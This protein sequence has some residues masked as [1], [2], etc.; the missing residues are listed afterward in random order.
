[1]TQL[2]PA[3]AR[4]R[5]F[6]PIF[7][8]WLSGSLHAQTLL[9][10]LTP[11]SSPHTF[12]QPR[13]SAIV[14][15]HL[16]YVDNDWQHGR[17][18]WRTDG[19][20]EGTHMV[21]DLTLGSSSRF[22]TNLAAGPGGLWF[23]LGSE[24]W[25]SDG[26]ALGAKKITDITLGTP[27]AIIAS[28]THLFL[29]TYQS[30]SA[31]HM[32]VSDGT[33]NGTSVVKSFTPSAYAKITDVAALG[34]RI[35]F[36]LT[37]ARSTDIWTSDGTSAGTIKLTG[38]TTQPLLV[39]KGTCYFSQYEPARGTE[40]WRTDG[41]PAGTKL[42][43]DINTEV[44]SGTAQSS[45]PSDFYSNG[46]QVY[47]TARR[48]KATGY[49]LFVTDGTSQ[50][51]GLVADI[52]PGVNSGDPEILGHI[53]QDLF[54]SAR[55]P[56]H[57]RELIKVDAKGVA[58]LHHEHAAGNADGNP[59][60]FGRTTNKLLFTGTDAILFSTDGNATTP[61][62][63]YA[64]S[65]GDLQQ[66]FDDRVFFAGSLVGQD[67]SVWVTDGS[68]QGT[69]RFNTRR[70]EDST[71]F[72]QIVTAGK[73]VL[74]RT[75]TKELWHSNGEPGHAQLLSTNSTALISAGD[76][77]YYVLPWGHNRDHQI[78]YYSPLDSQPT[79][80]SSLR[81]FPYPTSNVTP[82]SYLGREDGVMFFA[83]SCSTYGE[84]LFITDG[85]SAG[86]HIV[87]DIVQYPGSSSPQ[88]LA[89]FRDGRLLFSAY[90]AATGRELYT[91]DGT[92]TGTRMI[93][94]LALNTG[95]VD[96][97]ETL[98]TDQGIYLVMDDSFVGYK[99]WFTDG[100]AAGTKMVAMINSAPSPWPESLTSY[101]G[102]VYFAFDDGIHGRELWVS[103]GTQ[104]GTTRVSDIGPGS[105][106]G[107]AGNLVST[108]DNLYFVGDDGQHGQE[109]WMSDGTAA[110]SVMVKDIAPGTPSSGLSELFGLGNRVQFSADDGLHGQELW[111]SDGT[112]NG[113]RIISNLEPGVS[114]S[115]PAQFTLAHDLSSESRVLFVA[116]HYSVGRELWMVPVGKLGASIVRDYGSACA[117]ATP[118][119]IRATGVARLG[120][121]L[122]VTLEKVN[123]GSVTALLHGLRRDHISLGNCSILV[124]GPTWTVTKLANG[125]GTS[126]FSLAV[127]N[128]PSLLGGR[129][130]SQGFE[131]G[132]GGMAL[133][134]ANLSKGLAMTIGL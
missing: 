66:N 59:R 14:G 115:S 35:L 62:A 106:S 13:E 60:V 7:C 9:E 126:T 90:E 57:G 47:F 78:W 108:P 55:L 6:L 5:L 133:G 103:N 30:P 61:L 86:T 52:W 125:T 91:S 123:A 45:H 53:G 104:A 97:V 56:S 46:Q 112:A 72:E 131:L 77:A 24:L 32:Y 4:L 37:I 105:A 21:Q 81:L 98:V 20:P 12:W 99:L 10:N 44:S 82:V 76:R 42:V 69:T 101:K 92:E 124:G 79:L 73:N 18:L 118:P 51:T 31:A 63:S 87:K 67:N 110:G 64:Y 33:V 129:L 100:T 132:V 22:P 29:F 84:E 36:R 128:N 65:T 111:V 71:K 109:L 74:I 120:Q 23:M 85:T 41:T 26:T 50:G 40:L 93:A 75:G 17:E 54:V 117:T 113:T 89:F 28:T 70:K 68:A 119:S 48:D 127:P 49:E 116:N 34:T 96:V 134:V 94:D 15:K 43:R 130:Y 122:D 8:L 16:Y 38:R 27:T 25:Q 121:S 19:S 2:S 114:S 83:G 1:M 95:N 102:N 3:V 11:G 80:A 58:T 107:V 39:H 88:L